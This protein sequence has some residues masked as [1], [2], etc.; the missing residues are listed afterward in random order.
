[1][2]APLY[3]KLKEYSEKKV[4]PFHMPGHKMG[5]GIAMENVFS[6][7]IT[8]IYGFDNLHQA[9]G[10]IKEAEDL[11]AKAFG[12]DESFF[13]INGSSCG[14]IGAIMA[15]CGDE[16]VIVGRNCHKSV[17]DGIMLSGAEPLYLMPK[18]IEGYNILGSITPES[19]LTMCK[20]HSDAKA[21]IIVSPTYEGVV[22][23]IKEIS[24]IVHK[25]GMLL[26]VDEAHGAH[27]NFNEFFPK[28][29]V[30]LGADIVIQS[31]HKTLPCPTQTALLHVCGKNL[32]ITRLKKCLSIT[33]SSSPSYILMSAID[34]CREYITS[35]AGKE[36]FIE[37]SK[38]LAW[39]RQE[40]SSVTEFK[41]LYEG[42]KNIFDYD[43]SK[44]V[45]FS[46]RMNCVEVGNILR[47]EYNIELEM[48]CA[49]YLIA[50]TS[51]C[52]K[53]EDFE[54]LAKALYEVSVKEEKDKGTYSDENEAKSFRIIADT[55]Y[56]LP[57]VCVLPKVAFNSESVVCPLKESVGK[58]SAEFV[59]P[60]PP[61]IPVIAHGE[62]ISEEIISIL[63]YL[64]KYNINMVGIEDI[65]LE[66]IRV[67]K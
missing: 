60:Y 35:G 3:N 16:K 67:L 24:N 5:K 42:D 13:L 47:R 64:K 40:L 59:I 63:E 57:Q 56:P 8:E 34:K 2:S 37:Y 58:I 10:V 51:V 22:S 55:A 9:G 29:A 38:N 25:Q 33:Q 45:L 7:D 48:A 49:D 66:K 61:G 53:K 44:I 12:A 14:I 36:D 32:D 31:V 65:T 26:I 43:K 20:E 54:Y 50:M 30:E 21:V 62:R 39:L 4:Y 19:V 46:Q 17:F 1:M 27:F 6:L 41:L 28:S 15:F 52:D 11:C 23:D 18:V